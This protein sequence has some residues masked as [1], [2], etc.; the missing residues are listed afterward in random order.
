MVLRFQSLEVERTRKM[1]EKKKETR[2][3]FFFFF[4]YIIY[5]LL[6]YK[7][8]CKALAMT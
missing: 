5:S 2:G 7:N 3:L 4:F 8:P 1:E 6:K